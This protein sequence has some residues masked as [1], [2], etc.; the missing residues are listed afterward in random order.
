MKNLLDQSVFKIADRRDMCQ[1]VLDALLADPDCR[2]TFKPYR[3]PTPDEE[4]NWIARNLM[5]DAIDSYPVAPAPAPDG[6]AEVP[7]EHVEPVEQPAEA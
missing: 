7:P 3:R 5:V 6:V 2:Y 4:G 1:R